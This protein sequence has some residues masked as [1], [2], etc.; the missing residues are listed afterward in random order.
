MSF[1]C[2]YFGRRIVFDYNKDAT[3]QF[4]KDFFYKLIAFF[5]RYRKTTTNH[6]LWYELKNKAKTNGGAVFHKQMCLLVV[7]FQ[8]RSQK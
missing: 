2:L 8:S 1:E 5:C 6:I 7:Y 4:I 3:I